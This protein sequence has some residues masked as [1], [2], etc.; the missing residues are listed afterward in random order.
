MIKGIKTRVFP[1]HN[2][3]GIFFNKK[4]IRIQLDDTKP[5]T[6]VEYPEFYDVDIFE[7][8]NGLCRAGCEFCY[9][10]GNKN[11][12]IVPDAVE[13][14][15]NYFGQ[16]T[17]NQ[18]PFQI[19]LPGSG[20]LFE[21]PDW[22]E[23]IEAFSALDIMP[24]YTT[25]AMF[26]DQGDVFIKNVMATT[27][28]HCGGVAISC[29]PHLKPTWEKASLLYL[30]ENIMLNYH[31]IISDKESIDYFAEIYDEWKGRVDYFVL[32]PYG[33]QGRAKKKEID[34]DYLITKLPDVPKDIA[35]GANFYPYLLTSSIDV[36]LY[37]PEILS[38]FLSLWDTGT[39]YK[40]SF[41]LDSIRKK[42]IFNN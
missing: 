40:S 30:K 37:E 23:I 33:E 36:S 20:E 1:E 4:T 38:G 22:K 31:I 9:L 10:S 8:N 19:A 14:I 29:H 2:Y 18:K 21:H 12:K 16:M 26:L 24:N 39:L 7:T 15:K 3:K 6:E 17:E 34:W 42:N 11:G 5:I 25:N 28:K 32:L 13:K 41:S 27:K 35:F